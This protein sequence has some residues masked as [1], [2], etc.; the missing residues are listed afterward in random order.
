MF[1]SFAEPRDPLIDLLVV[2][3]DVYTWKVLRMDRRYSRARTEQL[4]HRMARSLR[5]AGRHEGELS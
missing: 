4:I 5:V 1:A 3:T 2:A